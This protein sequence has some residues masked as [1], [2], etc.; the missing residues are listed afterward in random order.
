MVKLNTLPLDS[1]MDTIMMSYVFSDED[2]NYERLYIRGKAPRN[3]SL[4][5]HLQ[6][7]LRNN[8]TMNTSE[9][10]VI[11]SDLQYNKAD[12]A[13]SDTPLLAHQVSKSSRYLNASLTDIRDMKHTVYHSMNRVIYIAL[14][15]P[16]QSNAND[17]TSMKD[18][19]FSGEILGTNVHTATLISMAFA[20]R[21][22]AIYEPEPEPV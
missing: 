11:Y 7:K 20:Y 3:V 10:E 9:W 8:A 2:D 15:R 12:G 5:D 18:T 19:L 22:V 17:S 14:R 6:V 16:K 21:P 13:K 1:D 4:D